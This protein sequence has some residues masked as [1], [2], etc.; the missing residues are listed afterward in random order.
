MY[1]TSLVKLT[2]ELTFLYAST[3]ITAVRNANA[4]FKRNIFKERDMRGT[5]NGRGLMST[6]MLSFAFLGKEM[7]GEVPRRTEGKGTTM[8]Y[9]LAS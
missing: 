3:Q 1:G 9:H 8:W 5:E 4:D 7:L 2:E 6:R